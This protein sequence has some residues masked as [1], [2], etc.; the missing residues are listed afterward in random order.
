MKYNNEWLV[1]RF[2]AKEKISYTFFWGHTVTPGI[3]TKSC[4]SQWWTSA[5]TVNNKTY[6]TAE[7]WMMAEKAR[8]FN[9]TAIEEKILQA[10]SP[11]RAK[12]LGREVKNFDPAKWDKEKFNIVV[13]GNLHKF[14]QHPDLKAFLL[15]T[16]DSVLV[17]ASPL[18]RIWG[19][20]I[21]ANNEHAENPLKWRGQNLLGYALM[22]VRDEFK[23]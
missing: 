23:K 13:K 16:R 17:E 9:D 1:T 2:N 6:P 4:F 18:D 7:H 10:P 19:I 12:Q 14:S 3:V 8:L 11:A 20:G 5:F 21:G 22:I 15:N